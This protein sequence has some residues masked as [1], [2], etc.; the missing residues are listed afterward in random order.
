V[1]PYLNATGLPGF[2]PPGGDVDEV[3]MFQGMLHLLVH[4]QSPMGMTSTDSIHFMAQRP[5]NG[6]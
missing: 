1:E 4:V 3:V 2:A 6:A 5:L